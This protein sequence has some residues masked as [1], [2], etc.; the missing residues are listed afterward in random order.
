[1]RN[2]SGSSIWSHFFLSAETWEWNL[3]IRNYHSDR[4]N[5]NFRDLSQIIIDVG[6]LKINKD[7][8]WQKNL[9]LESESFKRLE[10]LIFWMLEND[11]C[12]SIIIHNL[13][14]F[15]IL[16]TH[17][18]LKIK[19]FWVYGNVLDIIAFFVKRVCIWEFSN[20]LEI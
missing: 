3:R 6:L 10:L 16:F 17:L 20:F 7:Q 19:S 13:W 18:L 14:T 12:Q 2:G 5:E 1:M 4:K 9:H 15:H 8:N 11:L